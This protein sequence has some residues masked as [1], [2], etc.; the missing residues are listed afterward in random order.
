MSDFIK[1][2]GTTINSGARFIANI[3]ARILLFI[4][5]AATVILYV[6][7]R[8]YVLLPFW[9][10]MAIREDYYRA[11]YADFDIAEFI[12]FIPEAVKGPEFTRSAILCV[13]YSVA[14]MV[15]CFA[16]KKILLEPMLGSLGG[17]VVDNKLR[18]KDNN[19]KLDEM[20]RMGGSDKNKYH[21]KT[22][23]DFKNSSNYV[24]R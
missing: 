24:E 10:F 8:W 7:S 23:E 2:T 9:F 11:G 5:R 20:E 12:K 15:I 13:A 21:Q 18:I 17:F 6:I 1:K 19:K 3:P 16:I 22:A 4:V 14:I